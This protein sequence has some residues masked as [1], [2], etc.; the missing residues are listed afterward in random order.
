MVRSSFSFTKILVQ[1]ICGYENKNKKI[2][3]VYAKT[4]KM[5]KKRK[6]IGAKFVKIITS[7]DKIE[8]KR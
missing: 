4:G 7:L 3:K 1:I 8:K 6:Q 2:C 5:T